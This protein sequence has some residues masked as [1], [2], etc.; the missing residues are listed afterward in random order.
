MAD[1]F[2]RLL[3]NAGPI[4]QHRERAHGY[5]AFPKLIG[6]YRCL[7][8]CIIC[9]LMVMKNNT[10]KYIKRIGQK[11]GTSKM[12]KKVM[13]RQVHVPCVHASYIPVIQTMFFY[14]PLPNWQPRKTG[15]SFL[16]HQIR[17]DYDYQYT[18]FYPSSCACLFPPQFPES[19]VRVSCLLH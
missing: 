8:M 3:K 10:K 6:T 9:L 17:L 13:M 19:P 2:E 12:E 7:Y 1:I 4:G 5:F 16:E 15:S 11:T 18:T 14:I